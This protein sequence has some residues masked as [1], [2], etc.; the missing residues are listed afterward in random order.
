VSAD[1]DRAA[2]DRIAVQA[3]QELHARLRAAILRRAAE[4]REPMTLEAAQLDQLV[5]AAAARA[6]GVL[7]R[8]CLA[9]AAAA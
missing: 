2:A 6:G 9:S 1:A 7:W 4:A 5:D 3:R 8:R